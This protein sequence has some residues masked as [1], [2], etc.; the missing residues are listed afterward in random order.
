M[1]LTHIQ[2]CAE[3]AAL[4]NLSPQQRSIIPFCITNKDR[5]SFT[6]KTFNYLFLWLLHQICV[7][8][9]SVDKNIK[10]INQSFK[11]K[12][13]KVTHLSIF[14]L[15]A[16][17]SISTSKYQAF[18]LVSVY[19]S[20]LKLFKLVSYTTYRGFIKLLVEL[21]CSVLF[22]TTLSPT[23][24]ASILSL[25][26]GPRPPLVWALPLLKVEGAFCFELLWPS[27]AF[28]F[29]LVRSSFLGADTGDSK[30][31]EEKRG[32]KNVYISSCRCRILYFSLKKLQINKTE[33]ETKT[34]NLNDK[35]Q[36]WCSK[37]V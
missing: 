15:I 30:P 28:R 16:S 7:C 5:F 9:H 22:H 27:K 11:A 24:A 33:P 6:A 18:G 17:V 20:L 37:D 8:H 23:S 19:N 31:A 34:F 2:L 32:N 1:S 36:C 26:P 10:K 12:T 25:L 3:L 4:D 29:S 35:I 13:N 21:F 14:L